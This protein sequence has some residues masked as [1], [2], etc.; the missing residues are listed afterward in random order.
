ME[1]LILWVSSLETKNLCLATC[2]D[3]VLGGTNPGT[4]VATFLKRDALASLYL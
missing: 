4:E 3:E 1:L 2:I